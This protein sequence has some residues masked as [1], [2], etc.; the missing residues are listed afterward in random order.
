M[1][2]IYTLFAAFFLV[3]AAFA[4]ICNPSGNLIIFTNYDGGNL[5]IVVDVNIPNLKIGVCSYEGTAITISGAFAGNVTGV[6]YAGFNSNNNHCG[7]PISTSVSGAGS[8][9]T[10]ITQYPPATLS[11]PNGY[12][13]IICGYSCSLTTNQGGCNTVDQIENY[14]STFF[15]GT[16]IYAHKVQY[17]CWSGNQ[18]VSAGGTCCAVSTAIAE[19][20]ETNS[21]S[22][23][24]NPAADQLTII[25]EIPMKSAVVKLTD[26]NGKVIFETANVSG[27]SFVFDLSEQAK[28]IYFAEI[29]NEGIVS[30]KRFVKN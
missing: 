8:A 23:Y 9:T 2:K 30:R 22:V 6:A 1:K 29:S 27:N 7:A 19:V 26:I 24:P 3:S 10:D 21:I 16:H 5:N 25:S 14:F 20:S 13:M 18:A 15:P 12:S 4:Q 17:G 11:N 28:G